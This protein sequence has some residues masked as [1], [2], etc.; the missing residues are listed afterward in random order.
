M[1]RLNEEEISK[2]LSKIA[3][4]HAA[5]VLRWEYVDNKVKCLFLIYGDKVE[6]VFTYEKLIRY[7]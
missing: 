7:K 6:E 1:E 4:S 3:K 5:S 2:I